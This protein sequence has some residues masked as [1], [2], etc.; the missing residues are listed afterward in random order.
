MKHTHQFE[1]L[2]LSTDSSKGTIYYR[3]VDCRAL[4]AIPRGEDCQLHA[5]MIDAMKKQENN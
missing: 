5:D 1:E 3:C 4:Y 2:V